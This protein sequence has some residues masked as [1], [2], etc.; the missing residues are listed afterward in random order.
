MMAAPLRQAPCYSVGDKR[1]PQ[2]QRLD[3]RHRSCDAVKPGDAKDGN[4][5]HQLTHH[6]RL[7]DAQKIAHRDIARYDVA[8]AQ[9]LKCEQRTNERYQ[10]IAYGNNPI[11]MR[12]QLDVA[13][14]KG[15]QRRRR[16]QRHID[17]TKPN[18]EAGARRWWAH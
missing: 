1:A 15:G 3:R 12:D 17:R 14:I 10:T 9:R 5:G 4:D 7:C 11:T 2:E 8:D 6:N 13:Q 18:S 16:R